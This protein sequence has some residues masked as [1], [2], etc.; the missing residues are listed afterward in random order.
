MNH[1]PHDK[2]V[3]LLEKYGISW[4][5]F[6]KKGRLPQHLR[7]VVEIRGAIIT[8]L[9]ASGMTWS[10][11]IAVTGLSLG[12]IERG[13]KAV[14]N[15]ASRENR[16]QAAIRTGTARRGEKK[17]WLSERLRAAWS[18]GEFNF[19]IG[20][21]VSEAEKLKLREANSKPEVRARR[22][23]SSKRRWREPKLRQALLDYHRDPEV[24]RERSAAQSLRMQ[25]DPAKWAKGKSGWVDTPKAGKPKSWTRSS[26]ERAAISLLEADPEVLYYEVEARIEI[27]DRFV[28]PD[29]IVYRSHDITLV[30][31]KAS[32]ALDLPA[33]HKISLRLKLSERI[34]AARNWKFQIWTEKDRL[35]HVIG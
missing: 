2:L 23:E 33:D 24:R 1:G 26:Y 31:V 18:N 19:H 35:A 14:G 20:R 11:M 16:R 30:E 15:E 10:D 7:H 25:Q 4:E 21:K 5:A 22:S 13:T 32:W 29:L 8:E 17:P 6:S 9:H 28:L 12:A 3:P 27:D 34:A